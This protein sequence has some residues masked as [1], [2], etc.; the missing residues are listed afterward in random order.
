MGPLCSGLPLRHLPRH[1]EV[2]LD[3][4]SQSMAG[5]C[6]LR[7]RFRAGRRYQQQP[8]F[9]LFVGLSFVLVGENCLGNQGRLYQAPPSLPQGRIIVSLEIG[10]YPQL[11][12]C[13]L[14]KGHSDLM[15][16]HPQVHVAV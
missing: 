5:I 12:L 13:T 3:Q 4:G 1:R 2:G 8:Y 6:L 16:N 7:A 14:A 10:L 11:S 9:L 15:N